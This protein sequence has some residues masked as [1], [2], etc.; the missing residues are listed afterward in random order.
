M[1]ILLRIRMFDGFDNRGYLFRGDHHQRD[2][3]HQ[4]AGY[5]AGDQR[6]QKCEA[7]PERADAKEFGESAAHARHDAIS[8]RPA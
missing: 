8:F 1:R 6:D 3:I 7:E 2:Q 5:A 4:N